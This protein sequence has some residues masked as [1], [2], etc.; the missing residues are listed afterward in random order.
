MKLII[1]NVKKYINI[2]ISFA[3]YHKVKC[4]IEKNGKKS[5]KYCKITKKNEKK[6][7]KC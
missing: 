1:N 5:D 7:K 4:K 6:Q 3:F 2:V